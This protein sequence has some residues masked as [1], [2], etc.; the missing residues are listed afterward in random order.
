MCG[1]DDSGISGEGTRKEKVQGQEWCG[2]QTSGAQT[3]PQLLLSWE[4]P[5]N[6]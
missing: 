2:M 5:D 6:K 4:T 3:K 1:E